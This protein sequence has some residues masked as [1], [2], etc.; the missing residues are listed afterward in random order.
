MDTATV[1]PVTPVTARLVVEIVRTYPY[2]WIVRPMGA[3]IDMKLAPASGEEPGEATVHIE[4]NGTSGISIPAGGD[5][6]GMVR[7]AAALLHE[8]ASTIPADVAREAPNLLRL[9][10]NQ[11][12]L[13]LPAKE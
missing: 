6:H 5:P 13:Q 1:A 12:T 10:A 9:L 7:Q 8:A 4:A 2:G 3:H 11:L